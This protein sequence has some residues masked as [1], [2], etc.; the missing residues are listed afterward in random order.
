V[1]TVDSKLSAEESRLLAEGQIEIIPATGIKIIK[2]NSF[3]AAEYY[4]ERVDN[5]YYGGGNTQWYFARTETDFN[6]SYQAAPIYI[7]FNGRVHF[8][9][10]SC[11]RGYVFKLVNENDDLINI[12]D[13]LFTLFTESFVNYC[14]SKEQQLPSDEGIDS[15]FCAT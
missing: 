6:N 3:E 2:I 7:I 10:Y 12:A 15:C 9:L 8:A 5:L 14:C 13:P 11:G 4:Q 1:T